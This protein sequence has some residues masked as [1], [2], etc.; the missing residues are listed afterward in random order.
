MGAVS[1]DT[2][3]AHQPAE[4]DL[5]PVLDLRSGRLAI[6]KGNGDPAGEAGDPLENQAPAPS[7]AAASAGEPEPAEPVLDGELV[8]EE[9]YQRSLARRLA[10]NA[11][12][13]LP[14][15]WQ[16]KDTA[17]Q[18]GG[19]LAVRV[20]TGPF[21]YTTAVARG[22]AVT[23]RAWWRWV[24]VIDFYDA[25]KG[26]DRLATLWLEIATIRRRRTIISVVVVTASGVVVLIG[27]L[28]SATAA[29]LLGG[30]VA[31]ALLAIA[32]RRKDGGGG[33]KA[34][35][36]P[37]TLA[38]AM[39]GD[40]LVEAFRAAKLVGKDEGLAFVRT[41]KRDGGGWYVIVDLPAS[42]RASNVVVH[43]EDLAS[44][45]A[46]DEARLILERVRGDD[47][48]AGRLAMWVGD[49]DPYAAKPLP[50]PL[51]DATSWDFWKPAPFGTT[52][53]GQVIGL[54]MVWTSLLTGAI[55][56]MGKTYCSRIPATAA[57]LDPYVQLI[58][59]DGKGG[60][61][62]RPFEQVAHRFGRGD[63]NDVCTRLLATLQEAATDVGRRFDVLSDLD[64][65]IC[66]E[67][68]VTPEITRNPDLNMPLALINIDEIQV[69][70]EDETPVEVG[71]DAKGKPRYKPRGRLICDL[72]TYIAKKGPAAGY[73]LNLATQKPDAQVIPDRLRGQLGTRFALKV[74]TYQAS[75]TILG[76]GTYKAG[77]DASKLL[78]SHKGVGL[79]LGADGETELD[80]SEATTI[81][82]FLLE[83]AVIRAACAAGRTSR[84]AAGT[85][86]G[87]AVGDRLIRDV[88]DMVTARIAAEAD[89]EHQAVGE[90]VDPEL[91]DELPEV[92]SLLID[93]IEDNE[94]GLVAT[95]EL[96]RRI[97]WE[98]KALGE[99]LRA[100]EVRA[101]TPP[102]KRMPGYD[103]PVSVTDLDAVRNAVVALVDDD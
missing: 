3:P 19:Q 75:E 35:V 11:I 77:M 61:D 57:A 14:A 7:P 97:G 27:W 18:A 101:A 99:A 13:K 96:A 80:A 17:R 20:G 69:Y 38:W 44:A 67:S 42:R 95:A 1:A 43:R 55:P 30:G 5:A 74:M 49:S 100:A 65:T 34:T 21:R 47:G 2:G 51:A 54:P 33:R 63:D 26:S 56:R 10:A 32:G 82:T 94:H 37:R 83:I 88:D 103:N 81:R 91:V 72:L 53:R 76:A 71:I 12:A 86:T 25:A 92:L 52:A 60:K 39:D 78:K 73:M 8:T 29:L 16:T 48:H 102:K 24:R 4:Q 64:D 23:G 40:H 45:L 62:W 59:F 36:G 22:G 31:S 46:V 70:L 28:T 79:L 9:E 93:V 58:V 68:K 90:P 84:Q 98:P 15:H 85:L 50:W 66:P 87:D 41:P 89:H 6:G